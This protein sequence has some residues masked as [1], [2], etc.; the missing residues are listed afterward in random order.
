[1]ALD[2]GGEAGGG[3]SGP[4]PT[5]PLAWLRGDAA[6]GGRQLG[7]W[8]AALL[9]HSALLQPDPP[10]GQPP[11]YQV[12]SHRRHAQPHAH[13]GAVGPGPAAAMHTCA[14]FP[15]AAA[16]ASCAVCPLS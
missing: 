10:P 4:V 6:L 9:C 8:L 11:A 14:A 7:L 12:P 15:Q 1:V 5:A 13:A 3:A 16:G 2:P